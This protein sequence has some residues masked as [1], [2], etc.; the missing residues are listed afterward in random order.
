MFDLIFFGQDLQDCLDYFLF[1]SLSTRRRQAFS[2]TKTRQAR[3]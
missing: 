3:K 2:E 1:S